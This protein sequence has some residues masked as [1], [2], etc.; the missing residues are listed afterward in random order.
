MK[1][2]TNLLHRQDRLSRKNEAAVKIPDG[3]KQPVLVKELLAWGPKC[4]IRDKINATQFLA[5]INKLVSS[6][7]EHGVC[8]EKL[9][10]V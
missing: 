8:G 10:E 3:I 4:P 1:S 6:I 7:Q 2:M 9:C 5:D